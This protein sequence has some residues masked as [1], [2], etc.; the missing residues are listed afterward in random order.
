MDH[1]PDRPVRLLVFGGSLR[2]E[3]LNRRLAAYA[4]AEAGRLG[5][6]VNLADL[7]DWP[8]PS[9]DGDE[10]AAVGL[11]DAVHAFGAALANADALIIASPEYNASVPGILKN[12][13]DWG[14]RLRPQPFAARHV[15]LMSASPSMVGGNRGLWALRV[16][17]EHLGARVYPE[18]FS[19]AQAHQA[20]D[21]RGGIG[22]A[23]L[24]RR[25]ATTMTDFLTLVESAVHYPCAKQRWIEFL[26][27]RPDPAVDRIE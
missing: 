20:M 9:Y 2:R 18:M 19:L 5:A 11:S 26:G 10:E 25:F 4:A 16:P 12:L 14:S 24:A 7:R 27:E 21:E 17:L 15:L 8:L 13:I 22:D 3:S 1:S 6:E 23:E